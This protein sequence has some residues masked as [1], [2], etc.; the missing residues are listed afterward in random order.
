MAEI[1]LAAAEIDAALTLLIAIPSEISAAEE[2][3]CS[4]E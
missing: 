1:A 3:D 4:I 2:I